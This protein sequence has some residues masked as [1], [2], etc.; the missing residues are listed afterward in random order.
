[1]DNKKVASFGDVLSTLLYSWGGDTPPEVMW[2]LNEL[3]DLINSKIKLQPKLEYLCEVET[4]AYEDIDIAIN[5]L[6][7]V[8]DYIFDTYRK[9]YNNLTLKIPEEVIQEGNE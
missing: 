9:D 2:G 1:M 5:A 7:F 4:E 6:A 8:M 3:I